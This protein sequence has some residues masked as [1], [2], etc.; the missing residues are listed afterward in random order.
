MY[1]NIGFLLQLEN[2]S[3][4]CDEKTTQLKDAGSQ[5]V[6]AQKDGAQL[7]SQL[8]LVQAELD[9][10][11]QVGTIYV[12]MTKHY[13]KVQLLVLIKESNS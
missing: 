10:L 13:F 9:K 4:E 1:Q 6:T 2:M 12:E 11:K 8:N 3:T 7:N 5:L